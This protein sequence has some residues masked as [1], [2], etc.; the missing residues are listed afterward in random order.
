[1]NYEQKR[2]CKDCGNEDIRLLTKREAAFEQTRNVWQFRNEG[3]SKCNSKQC[4][5]ISSPALDL[6]EQILDEWCC[7][8]HLDFSQQDESII[9]AD[10]DNL[11][12]IVKA[13][14]KNHFTNGKKEVLLESLCILLYD[15]IYKSEEFT[16]IEEFERKNL[17]SKILPEL[18]RRKELILDLDNYLLDY[19]KEVVFPLLE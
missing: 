17:A 6:D 3:C 1:M 5:S 12:L 18:K 9:L 13:I 14:D 10:I 19:V 7:S 15:N 16:N 2:R 8:E 11:Q 4:Q